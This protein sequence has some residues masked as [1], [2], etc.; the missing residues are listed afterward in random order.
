MMKCQF[1]TRAFYKLRRIT[2]YVYSKIIVIKEINFPGQKKE[3]VKHAALTQNADFTFYNFTFVIFLQKMDARAFK[4]MV[5]YFGLVE[6]KKLMK[7]LP[8]KIHLLNLFLRMRIILLM[9]KML[10]SIVHQKM[11]LFLRRKNH[12][13]R[14][15]KECQPSLVRV[16]RG[17]PKHK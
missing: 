1:R 7:Q 8:I 11:K 17:L 10:K 14:E 3:G 16:E 2:C 13:V 5:Q 4:Q 6:L 15:A 12:Q 9:R